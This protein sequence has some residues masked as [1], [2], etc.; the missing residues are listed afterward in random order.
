M[1]T[2]FISIPSKWLKL[3]LAL[4]NTPKTV[5]FEPKSNITMDY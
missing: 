1:D 5:E 2:A 4:M 3:L